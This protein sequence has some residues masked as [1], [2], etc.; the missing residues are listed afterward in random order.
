IDIPVVAV[1]G[2]WSGYLLLEKIYNKTPSTTGQIL[3]LKANNVNSFDRSGMYG[4]NESMDKYS[5]Y[6][7]Y[8]AFPLPFIFFLTENNMRHDFPKLAFLYLEAMSITGVIGC[9]ATYTVDRYRPY[10]YD[11]GTSMAKKVSPNAKNSFMAG[12]VEVIACSVFFIAETYAVYYPESNAKWV[13]FTLAGAATAGMGYMRL[14]GGMHFPSDII[15]GAVTGGLSGVLVPY[16]HKHKIIKN[17]NLSFIPF[18]SNT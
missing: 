7:F 18:S 11:T 8:A 13:F 3:S 4:Y 12:H 5:Y 2:G 9:T 10:A 15:L 14:V 16:F 1:C 6:P 17:T